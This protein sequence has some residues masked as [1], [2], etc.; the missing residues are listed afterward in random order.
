[1]ANPNGAPEITNLPWASLDPAQTQQPALQHTEDAPFNTT[2]LSEAV[3]AH[4]AAPTPYHGQPPQP[5]ALQYGKTTPMVP[6]RA[7]IALGEDSPTIPVQAEIIFTPVDHFSSRG[8]AEAFVAWM[9]DQGQSPAPRMSDF[10]AGGQAA[11][12]ARGFEDR[13]R[14]AKAFLSNHPE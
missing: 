6:D 8:E 14:A 1:M 13:Y 3:P 4:A 11:A 5:V 12:R 2:W 9:E 7:P 10:N